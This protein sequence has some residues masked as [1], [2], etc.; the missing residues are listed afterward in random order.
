MPRRRLRVMGRT[1]SAVDVGDGPPIVFLHGNVIHSY[2][3]R[4]VIPYLARRNRCFAL[5]NIGM[6][7][8]SVIEPSGPQTYTFDEIYS[9]VDG[10][11]ELAD[12]GDDVVLVG[13]ELGALLAIRWV[14]RFTERVAGLAMIE[15]VF[16]ATSL[17]HLLPEAAE[18]LV[19]VR[20][21]EGTD[22]VLRENV[23]I[24]RYLPTLTAR[25][26]APGELDAYN[27]PYRQPGE[28]RRALLSL[29][30]MLPLAEHPGAVDQEASEA[31]LWCAQARVPKLVVG[32]NPGHLVPAS[33]LGTSARWSDVTVT[34]VRGKHYLME[35]SPARLTASLIGW[36]DTIGHHA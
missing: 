36:L 6:G 11:L 19:A 32:G 28:S 15:G 1:M 4:N 29:A 24:H 12:L 21:E 9:Y 17:Q 35:D 2:A 18:L 16:R 30:R 8:S 5:D 7:A 23:M 13:H 20:Q 22:L 31:R 14:R 27:R 33:I 25:T 10:A 26:L 34:S 3:W